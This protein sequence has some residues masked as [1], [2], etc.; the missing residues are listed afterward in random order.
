MIVLPAMS[1]AQAASWHGVMD[2]FERLDHGWTLVGGQLVHLHCAERGY[3]PPRPTD[4][5]DTVIDVRADNQMLR[6]FTA[7]LVDLGFAAGGTSPEGVQHRWVRDAAVIDVLLPDGV[8]E[9]AASRTGV[10]GGLTIP[11]PGGT[12]ALRRSETVAI[13]VDGRTGSVRRP[14]IVGALVMKAAAHTAP[15]DP[16][17]GRHRRDFATLAALVAARDFRDVALNRTDRKLLRDMLAAVRADRQTMLVLGNA[18]QS[19]DRLERAAGLG[20]SVTSSGSGRTGGPSS[21]SP[22]RPG[23]TAP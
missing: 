5:I 18:A 3:A 1:H 4:D 11:T 2:L 8:G 15:G 16:T 13:T 6:R 7:T 12:Q 20:S 22:S 14:D 23:G 10:T 21:A 19:L 17:K 9:R